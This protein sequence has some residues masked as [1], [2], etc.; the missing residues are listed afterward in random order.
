MMVEGEAK[1]KGLNLLWMALR[2]RADRFLGGKEVGR[3]SLPGT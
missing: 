1:I 2:R 3:R